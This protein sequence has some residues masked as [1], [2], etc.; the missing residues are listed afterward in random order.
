MNDI[1]PAPGYSSLHVPRPMVS[2]GASRGGCLSVVFRD[3]VVIHRHPL[4]DKLCPSTFELQLIR[5]GLPPTTVHAVFNIL[6]TTADATEVN[7]RRRIRRSA[8]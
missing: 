3:S 1:G 2:G 4:A 8:W 6:P 5:V 7:I